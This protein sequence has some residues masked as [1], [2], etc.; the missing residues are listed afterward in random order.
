MTRELAFP[1]T[2]RLRSA[3][4]FQRVRREGE[5]IH[6]E[7]L[8]LGVLRGEGDTAMRAGFITP[9]TLGRAV[10]RNRLRRRLREIVRRHQSEIRS[11]VWLVTIARRRSVGASY[12]ALEHEWLRLA[13]RTSILAP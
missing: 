12:R 13:K 1:K 3:A 7:L 8:S 9:R 5:T 2:R 4:E 10:A 11:N 6:G